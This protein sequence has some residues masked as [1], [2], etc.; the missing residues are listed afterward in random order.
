MDPLLS[1]A[2]NAG[3]AEDEFMADTH[4]DL[5]DGFFDEHIWFDVTFLVH[6]CLY[7]MAQNKKYPI[8]NLHQIKISFRF[9][10]YKIYFHNYVDFPIG[11]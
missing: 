5:P 9:Q 10:R 2:E 6:S 8:S 1:E 11:N 4:D 7:P 3:Q